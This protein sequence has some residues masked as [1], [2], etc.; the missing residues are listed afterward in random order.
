MLFN[1]PLAEFHLTRKALYAAGASIASLALLAAYPVQIYVVATS[2]SLEKWS[3]ITFIAQLNSRARKYEDVDGSSVDEIRL[4]SGL[5]FQ[6]SWSASQTLS[7]H[8]FE[9]GKKVVG[10]SGL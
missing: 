1:L 6:E 9:L 4:E 7:R 10:E 8:R 5:V 2:M 3:S